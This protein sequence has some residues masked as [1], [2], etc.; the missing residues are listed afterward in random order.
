MPGILSS[1]FETDDTSGA[2]DGGYEGESN[3]YEAS[4]GTD[5]HIDPSITIS[6]SMSGSYE[7]P[8][9]STHSWERTDSV[10]LEVD[11]QVVTQVSAVITDDTSS[12][13]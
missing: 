11:T 5:T 8:D 9:G 12:S 4:A 2:S 13:Y 7:S 1:I 10:T 6:N 3:T